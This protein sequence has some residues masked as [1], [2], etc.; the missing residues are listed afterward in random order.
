[1]WSEDEFAKQIS[2]RVP[3]T[4]QSGKFRVK[5]REAVNE[6]GRPAATRQEAF[7]KNHYVE[8][9]IGYDVAKSEREKFGLTSLNRLLFVGANGKTKAPYELGEFLHRFVKMGAIGRAELGELQNFLAN[10]RPGDFIA[11]R[12]QI[13]RVNKTMVNLSEMSFELGESRYPLL[14]HKI[15]K[16]DFWVEIVVRERQRALGVQP[17]L[18]VCFPVRRLSGEFF[19]LIGRCAFK[20]ELARLNLAPEESFLI[21]EVF[22]IFGLL[23]GAHRYDVLEILRLVR[24]EIDA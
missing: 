20:K 15:P 19:P 6:H 22:K 1:M 23:S 12:L 13:L 18:Y 17:M 14:V 5:A 11:E 10:L 16:T 9:Q 21:L 3:L 24:A 8:W 2:V 7:T 4:E